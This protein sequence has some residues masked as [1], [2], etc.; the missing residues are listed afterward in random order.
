MQQYRLQK[1]CWIKWNTVNVYREIKDCMRAQSP[2]S[3]TRWPEMWQPKYPLDGRVTIS[4]EEVLLLF[5]NKNFQQTELK[6]VYLYGYKY[7]TS[8]LVFHWVS[9][10]SVI[11]S[12]FFFFKVRVRKLFDMQPHSFQIIKVNPY[13]FFLISYCMFTVS[14][15]EKERMEP[16]FTKCAVFELSHRVLSTRPCEHLWN[17]FTVP[18]SQSSTC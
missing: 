14:L 17:F 7:G 4:K 12:Q 5:Q 9:Y 15:V 6:C 11:C 16:F 8:D 13:F 10:F 2:V 3:V 18:E 1:Y